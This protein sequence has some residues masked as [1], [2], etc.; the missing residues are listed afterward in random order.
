V[1][2]FRALHELA[3]KGG[4]FHEYNRRML[5]QPK[6]LY[7]DDESDLLILAS[8]FFEDA[9]LVIETCQ[10]FDEAV[11]KIRAGSYDLIISDSRMPRGSGA[12]LFAIIQ[13]EKL[14]CGKF[15]IVTGHF[16]ILDEPGHH[17]FD[18]VLFKPLHFQELV[19]QVKLL[20][21]I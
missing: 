7:L 19:D 15:V 20:L 3:S 5:K 14:V 21:K 10:D 1:L 4:L 8:S 18:L 11:K 9:G 12:Q 13:A 16:D 6:I 17:E 2:Y